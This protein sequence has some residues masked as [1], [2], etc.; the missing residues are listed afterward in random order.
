MVINR[1]LG[2]ESSREIVSCRAARACVRAIWLPSGV[3]SQKWLPPF[4]LFPLWPAELSLVGF[5]GDELSLFPSP[6]PPTSYPTLVGLIGINQ[7]RMRMTR[8]INN[9][10]AD[11]RHSAKLF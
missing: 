3:R 5:W 10:H 8:H 6:H 11:R 9:Y 1:R 4:S 2:G 7:F